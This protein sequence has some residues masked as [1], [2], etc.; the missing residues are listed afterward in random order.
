MPAIIEEADISKK[1]EAI[2]IRGINWVPSCLL[3]I[4]NRE[5]IDCE[6]RIKIYLIMIDVAVT[7]IL[8]NTIVYKKFEPEIA[9]YLL[10]NYE[11]LLKKSKVIL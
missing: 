7:S 2:E 4:Y 1:N 3:V 11:E 6:I 10:S 9:N 5:Q 8:S